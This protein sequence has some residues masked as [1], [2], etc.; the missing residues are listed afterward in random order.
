MNKLRNVSY[1]E[2]TH[3]DKLSIKSTRDYVGLT[4]VLGS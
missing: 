4:V 1:Y 2:T 3:Y